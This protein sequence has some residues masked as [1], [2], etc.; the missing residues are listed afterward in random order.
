MFEITYHVQKD[1]SFL[2]GISIGLMVYRLQDTNQNRPE[3][4]EKDKGTAQIH[5]QI[6]EYKFCALSF[7]RARNKG[8]KFKLAS[9]MKGLGAFD[10][11][12]VEYIDDNSRIKHIFLQLKSK[13]NQSI[14]M[15]QLLP[16]KG[17]FSL[18][19]YYD[20][21]IQ[22]EKKFS[23][24]EEE[25]KMEGTID[26]S[27]FII[28]SNADVAQELKSYSVIDF[29]AEE[30]LMTGGYVLQ[31]NKKEHKAIYQHLQELPKH[32]EFLSRLRI[33]YSQA[34]EKEMDCHIK[35]ELQQSMTLP[36]SEL[37]LTYMCYIDIMKDWWQNCNYFLKETNS[38]GNDPLLKTSEKVRPTLV[39]KILDQRKFELYDL[40]I[41]YKQPAITDM[42]QL[43]EPH[44]AVLIFAP[45]R[46]TTLTAAKIHQMLSDTEHVILNLQ[47]LIRYK[48][49]VI[50]AWKNTFE[51]V[52][53]DSQD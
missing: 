37:D 53:L 31:F 5:G 21:Y 6:F 11:V 19:K 39:A 48:S 25:V 8:Y 16:E 33:F 15:Q 46:S 17:N 35:P 26:E 12:V 38:K 3:C 41:K 42:K 14:T 10:D 22:V 43:I 30:F 36:D 45:G 32:R 50:L 20:S 1:L 44:K 49:E 2:Q 34:D 29:S 28:Y 52:V 18:R 9:N 24:S 4:Y 40:R 23:C 47:Q 7:L 51:I 13:L 27:L